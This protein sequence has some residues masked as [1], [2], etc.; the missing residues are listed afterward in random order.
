MPRDG[1]RTLS[2]LASDRLIISCAKCERRGSYSVERLWRA[3][4]DLALAPFLAELTADC[5]RAKAFSVY[6]RCGARYEFGAGSV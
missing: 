3:R 5:P 1:S 6:D 4:G 2:D